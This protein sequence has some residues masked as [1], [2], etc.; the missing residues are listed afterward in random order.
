MTDFCKKITDEVS[1]FTALYKENFDLKG[2]LARALMIFYYEQ[3]ATNEAGILLISK[4]S[5]FQYICTLYTIKNS[6]NRDSED[7]TYER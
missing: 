6:I 5:H 4:L 1:P 7:K 2:L 3:A